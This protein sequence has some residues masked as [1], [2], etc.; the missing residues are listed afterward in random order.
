MFELMARS[1]WVH[2]LRGIA[3]I[4]F[5]V[6]ALLWPSLTVGAMVIV[7]GVFAIVDGVADL[8]GAFVLSRTGGESRLIRGLLGLV[9]IG[10]GIVAFVWPGLTALALLYIVAI[11]AIV[12]GIGEIVAAIR[13]R[14]AIEGEWL[15]GLSGLL[16]VVFGV[17]AIIFPGSGILALTWLVGAYA[18]LFGVTLV[19]VG[20]ELRSWASRNRPA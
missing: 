17:I 15:L 16:A 5:G 14:E 7:F 11:W 4:V 18:I 3:A 20:F 13:L 10:A 1:W 9:S 2:V 12:I 19:A 6:V 8:A